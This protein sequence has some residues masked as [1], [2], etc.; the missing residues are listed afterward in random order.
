MG[1]VE[2]QHTQQAPTQNTP[3]VGGRVTHVREMGWL[4]ICSEEHDQNR[5][6]MAKLMHFVCA[7]RRMAF[8]LNWAEKRPECMSDSDIELCL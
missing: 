1:I 2:L 6:R 8:R 3:S 7:T 5:E 4:P